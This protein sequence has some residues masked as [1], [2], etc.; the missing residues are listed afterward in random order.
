MGV[1][2]PEEVV[3]PECGKVFYEGYATEDSRYL[4][5][6]CIRQSADSG[7]IYSAKQDLTLDVTL[8][9]YI[10]PDSGFVCSVCGQRHSRLLEFQCSHDHSS[11][12]VFHYGLCS[13]CK[14]VF[15][16]LNLVESKE[17]KRKFCLAHA[18]KCESCGSTIGVDEGKLCKASGARFC[19]SCQSF[20]K[21]V[22][23]Q[24]EYSTKSL[25]GDKCPACSNLNE[26][27]DQLLT[28][29]VQ[30]F[31]VSQRKTTKWLWGKN[32]LNSIVVAKGMFSS[33]LYVVENGKVVYQ[34]SISFFNKLRGR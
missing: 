3:C 7:K 27:I 32:A 13:L 20:S 29:V 4:C 21:C 30:D 22:S 12:C 18:A 34:K 28:R 5:R 25:K 19:S 2:S 26:E 1:S 11:V 6:D 23:C 15:S 9:E 10:E 31:D 16:E 17:S 33:T 24:Q 14:S 8:N